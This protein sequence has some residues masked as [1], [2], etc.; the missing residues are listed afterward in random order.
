LRATGTLNG[1]TDQPRSGD[2]QKQE[3]SEAEERDEHGNIATDIV[4]HPLP[5]PRGEPKRKYDDGY[6]GTEVGIGERVGEYVCQLALRHLKC[7]PAADM[8]LWFRITGPAGML[9]C[10]VWASA[11]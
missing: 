10:P 11:A 4:S 6:A 8:S 2:A 9:Q 5:K 1:A 3:E 7:R